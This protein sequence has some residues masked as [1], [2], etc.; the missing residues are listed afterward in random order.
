MLDTE[1]YGGA[2]G[3]GNV[4]LRGAN[5]HA[6]ILQVVDKELSGSSEHRWAVQ[7][8]MVCAFGTFPKVNSSRKG[9]ESVLSALIV[10][11]QSVYI[12]GI[13]RLPRS[14]SGSICAI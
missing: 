14:K 9:R 11:N 12:S 13:L 4:E 5:Y 1:R 7:L 3:Q 8:H 10:A 2:G 6:L